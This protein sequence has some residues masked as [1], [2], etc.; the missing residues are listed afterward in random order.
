MKKIVLIFGAYGALG[1]GVTK[2]LL[3]KDYDRYIYWTLMQKSKSDDKR[4]V[5]INYRGSFRGKK[6][7]RS[8]QQNI[9]R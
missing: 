2:T 7:R 4:V 5:N 1:T 8:I 3:K 6:C 9:C